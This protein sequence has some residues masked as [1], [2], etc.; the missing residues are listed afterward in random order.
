M[1]DIYST[2]VDYDR[3]W[4]PRGSSMPPCRT[5][6]TSRWHVLTAELIGG[7]AGA[8]QPNMGLTNW[9]GERILPRDVTFA[10]NYLNERRAQATTTSWSN[11]SLSRN[12]K[13]CARS[14]WP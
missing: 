6:S 12:H 11:T 1:T 10:K 9:P 4:T 7:R 14:R 5:S 2:S 3:M 8:E 13:P